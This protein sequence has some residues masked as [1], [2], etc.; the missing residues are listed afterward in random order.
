MVIDSK[1]H[2]PSW[3]VWR[4]RERSCKLN[5]PATEMNHFDLLPPT[6]YNCELLGD[7][8]SMPE[9]PWLRYSITSSPLVGSCKGCTLCTPLP[10][11]LGLNWKKLWLNPVLV[12]AHFLFVF[13]SYFFLSCCSWG[14]CLHYPSWD[15]KFVLL[16]MEITFAETLII[17]SEGC[18]FLGAGSGMNLVVQD[19]WTNVCGPVFR[20]TLHGQEQVLNVHMKRLLNGTEWIANPT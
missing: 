6:I 16:W 15:S 20:S 10:P 17:I 9:L 8:H 1:T 7:G 5:R 4:E 2:I 19:V 12:S 11:P 18:V 13:W 3:R 14:C